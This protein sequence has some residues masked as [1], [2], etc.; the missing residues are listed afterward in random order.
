MAPLRHYY[1][2]LVLM[3]VWA[4]SCFTAKAVTAFFTVKAV[5]AFFAESTIDRFRTD[6]SDGDVRDRRRAL[7]EAGISFSF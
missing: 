3:P 2:I 1:A 7:L 4:R 5:A 6:H